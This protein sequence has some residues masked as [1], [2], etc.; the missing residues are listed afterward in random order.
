MAEKFH[1]RFDIEVGLEEAKRRFVNRAF[2]S[3]FE[4]FLFERVH[5]REDLYRIQRNIVTKLG[6]RY[7]YNQPLCEYVGKDF[8]TVLRALEALWDGIPIYLRHTKENLESRIVWLLHESEVD[9]GIHWENGYFV[10][11]GA[12]L[13]DQ[14]LVNDVLRWLRDKSYQD[15]LTPYEKGLRHFLEA[16]KRP[17][18]LADVI[19]DTYEA[20]EAL[21]KIVTRL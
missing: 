14:K 15:I 19:T 1:E 20:L 17:E 9:L 16:D 6:K 21:A 13:L 7:E 3:I 4:D 5:S 2:N 18:M 12:E 8:Y 11:T 10:R